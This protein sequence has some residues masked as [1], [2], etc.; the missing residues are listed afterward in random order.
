MFFT[1]AT[2]LSPFTPRVTVKEA[3]EETL[4]PTLFVFNA[5]A[6]AQS[7]SASVVTTFHALGSGRH[8]AS[9]TFTSWGTGFTKEI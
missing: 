6:A 9:V 3:E 7:L 2:H 8:F 5:L 4:M 1:F